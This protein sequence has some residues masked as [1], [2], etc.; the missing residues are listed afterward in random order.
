MRLHFGLFFA[1]LCVACGDRIDLEPYYFPTAELDAGMVYEYRSP[2]PA[3]SLV[4]PFYRY[5]R[6]VRTDTALYLASQDYDPYFQPSIFAREQLVASGTLLR[7]MYLYEPD[8][9]G[10][11][12]RVD[13]QILHENAFPFGTSRTQPGVLVWEVRWT[14][15]GE[16]PVTTTLLRNRQYARDTVVR[17]ADADT[18]AVVFNV[19][20]R[21]DSE[22]V[23]F[24]ESEYAAVE[25][26]A[27]GIGLV[28]YRK[29]ISENFKLEYA[30]TDR[31][32]M[33]ELERRAGGVLREN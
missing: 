12:N 23:G 31:Y 16:P 21:V 1:L 29:D 10:R 14:S 33:A 22:Q 11:V 13:A 32:P 18:D 28:Y 9:A 20:E 24:V 5:F 6:T 15:P 25:V 3:D 26:Y 2:D 4:P 27:E 19:I 30:L 8:T 7:E 17:V